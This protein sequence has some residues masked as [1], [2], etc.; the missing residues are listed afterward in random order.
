MTSFE[1]DPLAVLD[2]GAHLEI[3]RP[4]HTKSFSPIFVVFYKKILKILYEFSNFALN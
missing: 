3:W 4:R 2:A 1:D